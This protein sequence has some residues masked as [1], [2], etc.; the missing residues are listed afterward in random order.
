METK[1]LN[2]INAWH[3]KLVANVI[4]HHDRDIFLK[5]WEQDVQPILTINPS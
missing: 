1:Y 3:S 4:T 5:E 2:V